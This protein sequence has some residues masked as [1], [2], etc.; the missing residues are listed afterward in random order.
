MV[1]GGRDKEGWRDERVEGGVLT[2]FSS[3][4]QEPPLCCSKRLLYFLLAPRLDGKVPCDASWE[5]AGIN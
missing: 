1:V 2:I 5:R 4:S 3:N